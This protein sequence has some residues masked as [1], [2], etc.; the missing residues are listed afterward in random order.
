MLL[1]VR[2]N[3]CDAQE[4]V[5]N[6][7]YGD[8]VDIAVTEYMRTL[9][10]GYQ[11]LLAQG[12]DWQVVRL[13]TDWKS[14]AQFDDVLAISVVT[15]AVG[16]TSFTLHV[17]ISDYSTGREIAQSEIVNVAVTPVNHEKMSIPDDFRA[18]L[19]EGAPG[20]LVNYSGINTEDDI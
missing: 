13:A 19:Q 17:N 11:E 5:F 14:S 12:I 18:K 8:Y 10:G 2:Y 15:A 7:R 9:F 1:R 3:E 4:V 16:N 20:V 6:A